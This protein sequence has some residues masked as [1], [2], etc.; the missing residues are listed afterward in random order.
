MGCHEGEKVALESSASHIQRNTMTTTTSVNG[1]SPQ[2]LLGRPSPAGR[3]RDSGWRADVPSLLFLLGIAANT[4]LIIAC[5]DRPLW[6]GLLAPLQA[7][8]LMGCQEA[9]HQAVHRKFLS[10]CTANDLV[11]T[12]CAAMFGVN[13]IA[14]RYF[15]CQHHRATCT[16]DDPEGRLYSLSW[17]TRW[18]WLLA[19]LEVPL[20]AFFIN[21]NAWAMVPASQ[22]ASR[23]AATACMLMVAVLMGLLVWQAPLVALWAYGIPLVLASW[24]DFPMTQ[25][26]HYGMGVRP[27]GSP[28]DPGAL[29]L[30]LILPAGMGWLI[31]HR[32]LHRVH[33]CDPGLR[34][35]RAP[36]RMRADPASAPVPY[37]A[38]LRLWLAKGPRLWTADACTGGA[39]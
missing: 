23:R 18:I 13:F 8:L 11:G 16:D 32:S 9:K 3:A 14:Y 20:V 38:F 12:V 33:H 37:A 34:W 35:F 15:H 1:S 26:E 28:H 4:G 7:L 6:L 30:D 39:R 24:I 31:L 29:T 36:A 17:P 19:P 27:S 10:H 21:K 22:H 5:I 2:R 25:A